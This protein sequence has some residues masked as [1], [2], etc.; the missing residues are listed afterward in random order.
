MTLPGVRATV[1][2]S[3]VAFLLS[4]TRNSQDS[5][6]PPLALTFQLSQWTSPR[7]RPDTAFPGPSGSRAVVSKCPAREKEAITGE[8]A[9]PAH[10]GG[11]C[12]LQ[13]TCVFRHPAEQSLRTLPNQLQ[14]SSSLKEGLPTHKTSGEAGLSAAQALLETSCKPSWRLAQHPRSLLEA[15]LLWVPIAQGLQGQDKGNFPRTRFAR[16]QPAMEMPFPWA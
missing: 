1:T 3:K 2:A 5:G 7:T 15:L 8:R 9:A 10:G 11:H 4:L 16:T 6:P 14:E 12:L 13:G